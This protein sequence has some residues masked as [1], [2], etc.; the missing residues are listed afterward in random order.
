MFVDQ[1][2][3]FSNSPGLLNLVGAAIVVAETDF[4]GVH[5]AAHNL[6]EDFARVTSKSPN[7]VE[8][9][10]SEQEGPVNA[11][12]TAIIVGNVETSSI[13]QR[14]EQHGKLDFGKIRGKWESY[15][16]SVVHN[17]F[18]GCRSALVIAGSDKRG[19]IFGVYSLSEQLGV[20]P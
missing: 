19:A 12:G 2:V 1:F 3:C 9:L 4:A 16:T 7:P 5:I 10:T 18:D 17:P 15:T 13:L 14:L 8:V 20:S 6:A 11:A